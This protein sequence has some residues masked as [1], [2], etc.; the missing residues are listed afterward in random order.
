MEKEEHVA[1]SVSLTG[2]LTE[3]PSDTIPIPIKVNSMMANDP[4]SDID[5]SEKIDSSVDSNEGRADLTK[6]VSAISDASNDHNIV[7][8]SGLRLAIIIISLCLSVFL[9]ALDQ[10][11]IATA[12]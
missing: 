12:M 1:A 7:Y 2:S 8:P 6:S 3:P 11:I 9:V 5:N 4:Q 10:T